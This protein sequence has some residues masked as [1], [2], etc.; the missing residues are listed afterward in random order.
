MRLMHCARGI[1]FDAKQKLWTRENALQRC[2]D[3]GFK[4][5]VASTVIV[6][7]HDS[8]QVRV[9]DRLAVGPASQRRDDL[10]CAGAL[11]SFGRRPAYENPAA[12]RCVSGTGGTEGT[13]NRQRLNVRLPRPIEVVH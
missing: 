4:A 13:G 9:G 12:A 8:L 3:A 2:F 11:R 1:P 10:L 6:E 7:T 5:A